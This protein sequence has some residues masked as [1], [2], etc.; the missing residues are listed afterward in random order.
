M[1]LTDPASNS[2][3]PQHRLIIQLDEPESLSWKKLPPEIKGADFVESGRIFPAE[4]KLNEA[5]FDLEI[6]REL[7]II[8]SVLL[9]ANQLMLLCDCGAEGSKA[10]SYQI[11]VLNALCKQKELQVFFNKTV[12]DNKLRTAALDFGLEAEVNLDQHFKI[13]LKTGRLFIEPI[14][15]EIISVTKESIYRLQQQI[16]P[17][18][19]IVESNQDPESRFIVLRQHKFY[20]HL[21]IELYHGQKTEKGK[22]KNPLVLLDAQKY[23]W[24]SSDPVKMKFF[25]ALSRFQNRSEGLLAEEDLAALKAIV[26]NPLQYPFYFHQPEKSENV[27]ASAL[28][29]VKIAMLPEEPVITVSKS[30]AAYEISA[31]V[32]VGESTYSLNEIAVQYNYFL[33]IEEVLCL[34]E[35]LQ[36]IRTLQQLFEQKG[37]LL[38]YPSKF[39]AFKEG[40]LNQLEDKIKIDYQYIPQATPQQ[41]AWG[42]FDTDRERIIY[43]SDFGSHVM[44]IP[45]MRYSDM[46][47]SVRS[48]RQVYGTDQKGK[49]FLVKRDAAEEDKLIS[50]LIKQHPDFEGQLDY[51]L[52]YFYLHKRYFLDE[53]WFLNTFE[54]WG[55]HQIRVL[56]FNEIRNNKFNP[57]K[58]KVDIKV[59][60]GINWFNAEVDVK[61]GKQKASLKKIHLA[62][63]NKRNY[64]LLDDGTQGIIPKEWIEK[65]KQYFIA[66]DIS[67]DDHLTLQKVNFSQIEELFEEEM[68]D[69]SVKRELALYREKA[70]DF[71]KIQKVK[72]PAGLN[73]K[74]RG[75]QKEGLNWL[76]FLDDFNFGGC[77]ADDMGLGKS[78]QIIAF[79]LLQ[80]QKRGQNT[81]LLVV[82]TTL[83]FNWKAE[84]EKFAPDLKVLIL[85]G[86]ERS[87]ETTHYANFDIILTSYT[88][89]LTDVNFLKSY[90]FNYIFLDESQQIKNPE[91]QRYKAVK[92]LQSR[93]KIAITG[94]PVENNTFDLYSQFSFACPGLL[95][96]KRYFKEIYSAPIDQFKDSKRAQDLQQK[97]RPFLLRRTKREVA[98]ELPEKTETILY[99]EMQEQQRAIYDAYEK[100]FRE[101]ISAKNEEELDKNRMNVLRGLTKLRQICNS[102]KLL[103]DGTF[104]EEHPSAKIEALME[105]I[106]DNAPHHKMLVFSQFVSMLSLIQVELQEKGIGYVKLTGSTKNREVVVEQ[107]QKQHN[108]RVFLISLKAGGTGLNL[109]QANYVYLVDPWWNPAVENQAIDR[110]HRIGQ[111]KNVTVIRM[112]CP[113][114][115]EEKIMRLQAGKKQLAGEL[116]VEDASFLKSLNK[117]ELLGFLS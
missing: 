44:I 19:S 51:P 45:V 102:T 47:I 104:A 106:E 40:L 108:I 59:L 21:I 12:R 55:N 15:P 110:V 20:H 14:K 43:L 23:L 54:E 46:E 25:M 88:T 30:E 98:K 31:S 7:C 65:F 112:I 57:N 78:V 109:E 62:V 37:S 86:P 77:L 11:Q 48:K 10:C 83:I 96:S 18:E 100:E 63:K 107:F 117:Q 36:L 8:V 64:V 58:I 3:T 29:P 92:L 39:N 61:F 2:T 34:I 4:I 17:Q 90:I 99:C 81:N 52:E 72:V 84:I 53:E 13:E 67:D 105:Q 87:R 33:K 42:S 32:K 66:A 5:V 50:L 68:L 82:P 95:G 101:Y 74:L 113:D 60:S 91:S 76:N 75:Y 116:I 24:K 103:S 85:R 6:T 9:E 41:L 16:Q 49:I 89:L 73:G 97:I 28:Q 80:K 70:E 79:V 56:G 71:T 26:E 22:L 114:T 27:I 69:N 38:V 115:V 93:N 1:T 35:N 111:V 94:T